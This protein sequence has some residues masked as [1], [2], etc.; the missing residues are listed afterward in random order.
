MTFIGNLTIDFFVAMGM[1]LGGSLLGALGAQLMHSAP[2]VIMLRLSDQLKIWA[3]VSAL[4]GTM[5]TLRI[6]QDG[7]LYRALNP[8]GKQIAYLIAAFV[9]CQIGA[10]MIRWIAAG[11]ASWR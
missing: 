10:L 11:D 4:G 9:G 1:V 7:V 2:L 6:I 8:L 3:M 5:D